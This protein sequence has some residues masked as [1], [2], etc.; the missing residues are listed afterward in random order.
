[1]QRMVPAV[2]VRTTPGTV[3][4]DDAGGEETDE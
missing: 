4:E 3:G 1:M 2:A